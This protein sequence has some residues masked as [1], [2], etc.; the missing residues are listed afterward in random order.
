MVFVDRNDSAYDDFT[1]CKA[2][3]AFFVH[4]HHAFHV[5]VDR[6]VVIGLGRV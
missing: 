3:E 5:V 4:V 2:L 1:L 6:L